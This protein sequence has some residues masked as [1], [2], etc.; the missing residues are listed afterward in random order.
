MD[1]LMHLIRVECE[2]EFP[3]V[4]LSIVKTSRGWKLG[5]RNA[6]D[7]RF[8]TPAYPIQRCEHTLQNHLGHL[9]CAFPCGSVCRLRVCKNKTTLRVKCTNTGLRAPEGCTQAVFKAVSFAAR[10][11]AFYCVTL[12]RVP[13]PRRGLDFSS[14]R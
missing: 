6:Q 9:G 11:Y 12:C 2:Y 10:S 4:A 8:R 1:I 5:R 14:V 13:H 7:E 3:A